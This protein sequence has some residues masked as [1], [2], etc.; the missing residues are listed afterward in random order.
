MSEKDHYPL[1]LFFFF[2]S[3]WF[4]VIAIYFMRAVAYTNLVNATGNATIMK[5]VDT[6]ILTQYPVIVFVVAYFM[7]YFVQK[8][9]MMYIKPK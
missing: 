8:V 6:A 7:I 4:S 3:I 5:V 1:K 2:M 9:F